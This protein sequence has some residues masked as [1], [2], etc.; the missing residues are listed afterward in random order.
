MSTKFGTDSSIC[1]LFRVQTHIDKATDDTRTHTLTLP[2]WDSDLLCVCVLAVFRD[3][4][5]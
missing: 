3:A 5:E 1:F 2:A 4:A